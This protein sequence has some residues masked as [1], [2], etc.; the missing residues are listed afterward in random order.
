MTT[1][2]ILV[3]CTGNICRSPVGAALLRHHLEEQGFSITSAGTNAALGRRPV[4]EAVSTV[5]ELTGE[6]MRSTAVQISP[7]AA[8]A[9]DLILTMT[10]GQRATV[11]TLSPHSVRHTFT[12]LEFA[13]ITE[14]LGR[15]GT[16]RT[17]AELVHVCT[18]LRRLANAV[19][20]SLDIADPYGGPPAGYMQSFDLITQA[21][22]QAATAITRHLGAEQ[23]HAACKA[24]PGKHG[25]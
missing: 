20:G 6:E 9:A 13:R 22:E 24:N 4:P 15:E 25:A 11:T 1:G 14:L 21:V 3:V 5:L 2:T 17:L 23:E 16:H 19:P 18:P 8:E 10:K 12:L 7:E